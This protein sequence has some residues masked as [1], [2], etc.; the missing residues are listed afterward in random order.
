M[1]AKRVCDLLTALPSHEASVY[2]GTRFSVSTFFIIC[3]VFVNGYVSGSK[4]MGSS[5]SR[6][7]QVDHKRDAG[8]RP[9]LY[10]LDVY[11]NTTIS[12]FHEMRDL[13]KPA[14]RTISPTSAVG[15]RMFTS[16]CI[17]LWLVGC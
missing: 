4:T 9:E 7:L 2:D 13:L 15:A 1:C 16:S 17:I 3:T 6:R 10:K 8:S 14:N 12:D 5:T 11:D